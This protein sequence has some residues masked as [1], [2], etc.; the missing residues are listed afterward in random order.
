MCQLRVFHKSRR[1]RFPTS[2]KQNAVLQLTKDGKPVR[3]RL[4]QSFGFK[5]VSR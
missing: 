2:A 4:Q 3:F 1:H 5:L